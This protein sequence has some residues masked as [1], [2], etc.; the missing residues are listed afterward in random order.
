MQTFI[1]PAMYNAFHKI[2]S[3]L[4]NNEKIIYTVAGPICE[5]SDVFA[6]N[7]ELPKQKSGN[8]LAIC[9]TGA[10]GFVMASNYNSNSL[11]AEF[12]IHKNKYAII[13][14]NENIASLI[15]KDTIPDWV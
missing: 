4:E 12:L 5:T 1:R 11:P 13:R 9:D 2:L 3:L 10:Y 14:N 7:I 15:E 8:Y 6:H